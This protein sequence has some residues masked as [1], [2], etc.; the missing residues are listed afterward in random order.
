M[1]T[2][3][4][5]FLYYSF[6]IIALIFSITYVF[7]IDLTL[8]L[9]VKIATILAAFSAAFSLIYL[10]EQLKTSVEQEKTK[11][12]YEYMR[13]YNDPEFIK[14]LPEIAKTLNSI[15]D[16][17]KADGEKWKEL[18]ENPDNW[19]KRFKLL[20]FL[21]FFEEM[22]IMYNK[23]FVNKELIKEFFR[24]MSIDSYNKAE[25]YIKK[26]QNKQEHLFRDW[27]KMNENFEK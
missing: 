18:E 11:R 19:D 23:N 26:R 13:R 4:A 17:N 27:T 21:N 20:L 9:F 24:T 6:L 25:K 22:A 8:D 3:E 5:L 12:A 1:T 15:I 16:E 2:K 7:K 14:N 10:A